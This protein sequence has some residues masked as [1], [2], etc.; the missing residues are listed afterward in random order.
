MTNQKIVKLIY[1]F[2][3]IVLLF[4]YFIYPSPPNSKIGIY[5][6]KISICRVK[7]TSKHTDEEFAK[8]SLHI[9]KLA[10]PGQEIWI[11]VN[12]R[13]YGYY[14]GTIVFV[15]F[16]VLNLIAWRTRTYAMSIIIYLDKIF[17]NIYKKI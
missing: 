8:I 1:L 17:K 4:F 12:S 6:E 3:C 10:C 9:H 11:N 15:F 13:Y 5:L 16:T 7:V 14:L 2:T